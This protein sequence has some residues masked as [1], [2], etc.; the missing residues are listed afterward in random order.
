MPR[1]VRY[2]LPLPAP[3]SQF[4]SAHFSPTLG[5]T[6]LPDVQAPLGSLTSSQNVWVRD[7][8][9]E[10]RTRLARL[11]TNNPWQDVVNGAF[12]YDDIGG[13]RYPVVTSRRTVA[14]L[15]NN[16]W[17]TLSYVQLS[18]N[19]NQP[20]SGGEND[21]FF[22]T[23][24][25]LERRDLNIGI[26]V[27]GVDPAFAWAGPT[28]TTFSTLTGAP[29]AHDVALFDNRPVFW[30]V[31]DVAT[32]GRFVTRAQWTVRGDPEDFTGIGA[33]TDDLVDMRGQGTRIFATEDELA[34]FSTQ[35][36]WRGRRVGLPFVFQFQPLDK[37]IGAAHPRAMLQTQH[38]IFWLHNDDMVYVL[39]NGAVQP[40]GEKIQRELHDTIAD[41][42]RAFFTTHPDT[43][44]TTLWYTTTAGAAPNRAFSFNALNGT[45][46]PHRYSQR[47]S[48]GFTGAVSSSATTWGAL[49]GGYA[50]QTLT[51]NQLLGATGDQSEAVVSSVG[52]AYIASH[53]ATSDDGAV[54]LH[55]AQLGAFG[56]DSPQRRKFLWETRVDVRATSA[57]SL[58]LAVSPDLGATFPAEQRFAIS[59]SSANT[60]LKSHTPSTGIYHTV[61]VRDD[62]GGNWSLGGVTLTA[63]LD[64]EA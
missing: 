49:V 37:E 36:V 40:I 14:F 59:A 11:G 20:P 63:R 2:G 7:G 62:S 9:L 31:Y 42:D 43:E 54:V 51:Y 1:F 39:Q 30:N 19:T 35:E 27:N 22:G 23:S 28:E 15:T 3:R 17:S 48:V 38:G 21:L 56:T 46:A 26:F 45:W 12:S 6:N 50:A 24:V 61:R 5:Y 16:A 13:L 64:G 34:L 44:I 55:E 58:S 32:A 57:S 47:C 60:Q 52:T 41:R 8:R 18:A 53:S 25:Y 33:G 10:P 29:I 4:T